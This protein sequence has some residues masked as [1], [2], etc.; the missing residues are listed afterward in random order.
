MSMD[1]T[2]IDNS[3]ESGGMSFSVNKPLITDTKPPSGRGGS[4]A[5]YADKKLIVFGGHF[6][7]GDDKFEYLNETWLLDVEKLNW[8]KINC[9]GDIPGPRYGH[10][11]HIL[12]S[13]MFIFGG[14][15]P[16]NVV[17]KDVYFLDL[18]EWVWV[19]VNAISQTPPPRFFHASEVVGR[20]IVLQGGW[21]GDEVLNDLWIFNTDSFVWIQ[22]R[23]AGFAPTPR[24]GHTLN[25][26]PDGRLLI[27]GGCS[28]DEKSG[29]PKYNNDV[30]QLDTDSMV[31][32]RPRVN[33]HIPT[34][35]YGHTSNMM[36][37]GKVVIYGGWGKGGCQ[38]RELINENDAYTIQVLD[39]KTMTW[40]VPRKIGRKTTKHLYNH[41][42]CRASESSL[43]IH[44]GFDGR[45]ALSDF[46]VINFDTGSPY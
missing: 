33:G 46:Y 21:D 9:S 24:Y 32:S 20:K 4:T 45:Q 31:W 19:P 30:R 11:A 7:A 27:I 41:V 38:S 10:T 17:Y 35:R 16:N 28:I 13:R 29:I 34:P 18:T 44:G 3:P 14:K 23:T 22:P 42:A 15:G 26:T 8:H 37:D 5:V 2:Q 25:L 36:D 1:K 40:W 43:L 39:T 6:F 12:G